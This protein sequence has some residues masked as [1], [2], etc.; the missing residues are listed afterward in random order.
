[1]LSTKSGRRDDTAKAAGRLPSSCGGD[2][3]EAEGGRATPSR[4]S[5][6]IANAGHE[7]PGALAGGS[8]SPG[9]W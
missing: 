2:H 5:V 1:M 9:M 6:G 8:H 7:P 4:Q 3:A